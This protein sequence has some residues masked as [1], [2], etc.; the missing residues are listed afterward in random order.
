MKNFPLELNSRFE[1]TK[2]RISELKGRSI[3]IIQTEEQ[4]EKNEEN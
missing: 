3:K 2:E 1:L 4:K